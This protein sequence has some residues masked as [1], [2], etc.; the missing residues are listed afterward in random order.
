MAKSMY[1]CTCEVCGNTFMSKRRDAHFCVGKSS[2]RVKKSRAE[3][4]E[5]AIAEQT[6]QKY[7]VDMETMAVYQIM[8]KQVPFLENACVEVFQQHGAEAFKTLVLAI[9]RGL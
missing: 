4:R 8:L 7:T 9:A 6:A 5:K 3:K 2:C 1:I